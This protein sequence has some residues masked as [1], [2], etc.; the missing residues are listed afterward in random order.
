MI[1]KEKKELKEKSKLSF[2]SKL[3]II[4]I[5]A[6]LLEANSIAGMRFLIDNNYVGMA[7]S[8]FITPFV[9]LP[10][11]HFTIEVK[12]LKE[13]IWIACAFSTGFTLGVILIR[14]FFELEGGGFF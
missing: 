7:I 5:S 4:F 11:N 14:P 12:T 8:V 9:C 1:K 6:I 13:R 10:M 2:K 3:L